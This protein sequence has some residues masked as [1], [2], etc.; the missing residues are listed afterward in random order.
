MGQESKKKKHTKTFDAI[1]KE[2]ILRA[3]IMLKISK[4][5]IKKKKENER[6][7]KILRN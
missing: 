1:L 7:K 3:N 2:N 4:L 6:I 5:S